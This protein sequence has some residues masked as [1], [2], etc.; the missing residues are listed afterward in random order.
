MGSQSVKDNKTP[1][2]HTSAPPGDLN[3]FDPLKQNVKDLARAVLAESILRAARAE[4][5]ADD[6]RPTRFSAGKW[7]DYI[8][9]AA[10]DAEKLI[11]DVPDV[12]AILAKSTSDDPLAALEMMAGRTRPFP[13]TWS[14]Q[15]HAY[16]M[17]GEWIGYSASM[18]TIAEYLDKHGP[19]SQSRE[20]P[21]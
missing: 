21:A 20:D 8:R 12:T 9:T 3:S 5:A 15:G 1:S 17:K 11:S 18:R 16:K 13:R 7:L 19:V 6:A 4:M 2:S 10:A 14:V